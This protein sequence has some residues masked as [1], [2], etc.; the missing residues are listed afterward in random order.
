MS[1][2]K[3]NIWFSKLNTYPPKTH[4]SLANSLFLVTGAS[5]GFGRS[6]TE[7]VL[8]N[9]GIAIA[10]LR[11]PEV[12]ADLAAKHSPE[13][14]LVLKLDVTDPAQITA[15]FSASKE[16]F[17]HID[18]VFNNAGIAALSEVEG[19]SDAVARKLF[20]VSFWGAAN[21]SREA[22]KFFREVNKPAGGLLL[23]NSSV[24][25]FDA[26]P[27]SGYYSATYAII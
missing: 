1:T 9:G 12:L 20:E 2:N 11:K 7:L 10:T 13:K 16:R 5:S 21:V 8:K 26:M 4:N 15:A 22:V 27:L 25:A 6:M 23:Q 3:S 18:V 14:L 24:A 19:T 17:G